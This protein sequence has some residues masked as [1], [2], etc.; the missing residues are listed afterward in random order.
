MDQ[1]GL[2]AMIQA[3]EQ[4]SC[5]HLLPRVRIHEFQVELTDGHWEWL[6][7]WM[8]GEKEKG[9]VIVRIVR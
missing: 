2:E 3:I 1:E 7:G 4:G 8:A 9:K 5:P 6:P